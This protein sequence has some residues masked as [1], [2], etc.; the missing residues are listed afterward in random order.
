MD[1]INLT[2][3][4]VNIVCDGTITVFAPSGQVARC[5]QETARVGSICAGGADVPITRTRFGQVIDLPEPTLG[6]LYI[7]SRIVLSACP[8]RTDLVVPNELVRD[9]AGNIVGCKSLAVN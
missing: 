4:G 5:A 2:P 6:T 3:H 1:I 7:V 8:M 9:G